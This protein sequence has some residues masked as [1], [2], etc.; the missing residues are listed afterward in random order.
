M[1]IMI[2]DENKKTQ[3]QKIMEMSL[4]SQL[5]N[6]GKRNIGFPS[7]NTYEIMYSN[8]DGFLWA[9]FSNS[10]D[11]PI[12]RWWNA[13]GIFNN[14][15]QTQVPVVEINVPNKS[16]SNMVARGILECGGRIRE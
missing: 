7:G 13:F 2:E 14:N 10:S 8:G 15:H 12:S 4:I 3:T 5:E 1:L 6:I 11:A 9:A 16:I